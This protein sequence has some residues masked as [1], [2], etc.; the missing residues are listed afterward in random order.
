[1]ESENNDPEFEMNPEHAEA[2]EWEMSDPK[3]HDPENFRYIV[4]STYDIRKIPNLRKD[5]PA[6]DLIHDIYKKGGVDRMINRDI[7]S[8]SL[9][10]QDHTS[11]FGYDGGLILDVPPENI[12]VA[13]PTDTGSV[14]YPF[15]YKDWKERNTGKERKPIPSASDVLSETGKHMTQWNEIDIH[16]TNPYTGEQ[17]KIN[18]AFIATNPKTGAPLNERLASE[19]RDLAQK[20]NLPV[21][22]IPH[23]K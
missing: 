22:D 20:M 10:D 13:S 15:T 2:S 6:E 23:E 19:I 16:P 11:T 9:I 7:L 12:I 1:M 8:T 21:I 3:E 5:I 17:V 18:G 4:Y 14:E